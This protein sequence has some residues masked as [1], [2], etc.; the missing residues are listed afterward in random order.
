MQP[1][2]SRAVLAGRLC[3]V[4][5]STMTCLMCSQS[6]QVAAATVEL[7]DAAAVVHAHLL[8]SVLVVGP[9]DLPQ[10]LPLLLWAGTTRAP[11]ASMTTMMLPLT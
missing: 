10:S 7:L 4:A 9:A 8:V 5:T 1:S 3:L 2:G 11:A 6:A